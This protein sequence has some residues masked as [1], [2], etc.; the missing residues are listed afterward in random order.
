MNSN[1]DIS[2]IRH[3]YVPDGGNIK[4]AYK[5]TDGN[6]III[7]KKY[8]LVSYESNTDTKKYYSIQFNANGG[9]G[10]AIDPRI[11]Y[12][13]NPVSLPNPIGIWTQEGY[14]INAST[15]WNTSYD[16][17]GTSYAAGQS[18]VPTTNMILYANWIAGKFS[19]TFN[20]NNPNATGSMNPITNIETNQI[21][22]LPR[23]SFSLAGYSFEMWE[24]TYDSK[25]YYYI[26]EFELQMPGYNLTLYAHWS[27]NTY[28][29]TFNA[30]GGSTP[31]P[32]S[33]SLTY[34]NAYGTLATTSRSGY[35]FAGW[36]DA[37]TGGTKI[38]ATTIVAK[39]QDHILLPQLSICLDKALC[40]ILFC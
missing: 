38:E 32:Q 30:N 35:A 15:A 5:I 25:T 24:C 26:D 39:T 37:Q 8:Y 9:T 1:F 27:A 33:K 3:I 28:T 34:G 11:S 29:V 21:V 40:Q 17:T 13:N 12:N 20:K 23:C 31:V 2:N 16:G 6:N 18:I 10:A 4:E 22:S 14:S 7:Y 19:I 36:Y